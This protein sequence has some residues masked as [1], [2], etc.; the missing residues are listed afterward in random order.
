VDA[1][2]RV[3]EWAEGELADVERRLHR[4]VAQNAIHHHYGRQEALRGVLQL[5][6]QLEGE[7]GAGVELDESDDGVAGGGGKYP[8]AGDERGESGDSGGV[9]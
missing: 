9:S 7:L 1:L 6:G 8:A 5:V 3:R 4:T 2:D